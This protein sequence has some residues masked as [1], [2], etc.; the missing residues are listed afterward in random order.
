MRANKSPCTL[1]G[2][3]GCVVYTISHQLASINA[4]GRFE[5]FAK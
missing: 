3:S 4:V 5:H 2:S 1:P